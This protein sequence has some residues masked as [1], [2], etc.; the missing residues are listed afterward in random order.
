MSGT[1]VHGQTLVLQQ[2]QDIPGSLSP[3]PLKPSTQTDLFGCK[4]ALVVVLGISWSTSASTS[5]SMA[6]AMVTW[7]GAWHERSSF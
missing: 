6:T 4:P 5:D 7:G 3:V 2:R 1:F